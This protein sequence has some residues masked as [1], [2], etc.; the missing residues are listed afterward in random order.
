LT[1]SFIADCRS[2]A[3]LHRNPHLLG[4][5]VSFWQ[6]TILSLQAFSPWRCR[7]VI[8]IT[9][10][11]GKLWALLIEFKFCLLDDFHWQL[12]TINININ[13]KLLHFHDP[14]LR[15]NTQYDVN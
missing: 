4:E 7:W 15:K 3:S 9:A 13:S 11:R 14:T 10:D 2:S 5:M 8:R 6:I 1:N 12:T